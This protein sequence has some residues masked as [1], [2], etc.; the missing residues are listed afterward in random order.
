MFIT[1]MFHINIQHLTVIYSSDS[2][3][4]ILKLMN[5]YENR[6]QIRGYS[7]LKIVSLFNKN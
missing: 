1:F 7:A 4:F 3:L 5:I 6:Y 2:H